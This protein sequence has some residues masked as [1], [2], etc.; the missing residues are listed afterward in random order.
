[1][2]VCVR[3]S[4]LACACA[5]VCARVFFTLMFFALVKSDDVSCKKL[6]R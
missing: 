2:C 3:V 6:I 1:M 5:F 4:V